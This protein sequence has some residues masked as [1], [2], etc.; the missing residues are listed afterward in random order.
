MNKK[1][2][3]GQNKSQPMGLVNKPNGLSTHNTPTFSCGFM[4]LTLSLIS[5]FKMTKVIS[6]ATLTTPTPLL[7]SAPLP[8]F[9]FENFHLLQ[10]P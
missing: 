8:R 4:I 5:S 10:K 1:V 6:L 3:N 7:A 9:F 2:P